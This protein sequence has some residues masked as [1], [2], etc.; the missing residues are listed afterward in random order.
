M[1]LNFF[2]IRMSQAHSELARI[3]K[4]TNCCFASIGST[5]AMCIQFQ[6]RHISTSL[7]MYYLA[8]CSR[9]AQLVGGLRGS[10]HEW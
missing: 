8:F 9:A 5:F 6:Y 3:A 10:D 2:S 7:L 4:F 1:G